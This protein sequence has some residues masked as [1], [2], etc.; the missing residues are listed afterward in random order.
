[1][2][3]STRHIDVSSP[4][5]LGAPH[6]ALALAILALPGSILPW[7]WFTAGG[8]AIGVPLALA[9]LAIGL[10]VRRDPAATPGGRR[11]GTAAA[12]VAVAVLLIPLVW[13][14]ASVLG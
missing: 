13:I 8:L 5:R 9:G 12:L 4:G 1:M 6:L 3:T 14:I 7:D 11:M 10:R 2:S